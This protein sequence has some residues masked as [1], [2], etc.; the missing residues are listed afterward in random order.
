MSRKQFIFTIMGVLLSITG[1]AQRVL[2]DNDNDYAQRKYEFARKDTSNAKEGKVVPIEVHQWKI[3]EQFGDVILQNADTLMHGFQNAHF[4]YGR[5]GEY[6]TL[7]GFGS[8][9]LSRI[10]MNRT[11]NSRFMFVDPYSYWYTRVED[12]NFTNT[13]SPYTNITYQENGSKE[14]GDDRI[15][16]YFATNI[17]KNAGIGF[18]LDYLYGRGFYDNQPTSFFDGSLYGYYR[19]DEYDMHAWFSAK[20][21]KMGENGGIEDDEY[22]L[23]PESF[24]RSYQ[25]RDIPTNLQS[26]WNRNDSKTFYLNHHYNMGFYRSIPLPDSLRTPI[27]ADSVL[28]KLIPDSVKQT[29]AN[30][31][32]KQ[33][34]V[35]DSI[36]HERLYE[37][38]T[39]VF[40][41]VSSIFHTMKIE[42]YERIFQT[43]YFPES[44]YMNDYYGSG[45]YTYDQTKLFTIKNTVGLQLKEGFNKWAQAGLSAFATYELNAYK[46]PTLGSNG[47]TLEKISEHN[48]LV[49]G[50]LERKQGSLLHYDV[51][52]EIN[53][54]G[55]EVGS[56]KLDGKGE[57]NF[58]VL[59][60]TA[61]IKLNA[62]VQ[63]Q[64]PSFYFRHYHGR[65]DW[66]DNSLDKELRTTVGGEISWEKTRTTLKANVENITNYTYF[67]TVKAPVSQSSSQYS[68]AAE[69]KQEGGSIQ[70][71]TAQLLQ[72]FK[73]GILNWENELT[74]QL[75][76]DKEALPLPTFNAYSNLYLK[77][78]IAKV[79]SV[80]LGVDGFFF[81]KYYAPDYIP[82][83]GQY[84][85][86]AEETKTELG[87]TPACSAYINFHL[88]HCRFY[89][90]YSH[91][92]GNKLFLAPHYPITPGGLQFGLSWNFFN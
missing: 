49:G 20:H 30:L 16:A 79:L 87:G 72:N 29:W 23:H 19:G 33:Q 64:T 45:S 78:M 85:T 27:P 22:I 75:S 7:G 88:K 56:F 71:I 35:L 15:R 25:M 83:I 11:Q 73:W 69:V 68:M 36:K 50:R 48:F 40:V 32:G 57:L 60:D 5:N 84:A 86:Q 1:Y 55:E 82:G 80:E 37:G 8:P 14:N 26:T 51:V 59:G 18:K 4:T 53:I 3:N 43:K 41:P 62:K 28:L 24:S 9:R 58:K 66:W 54:A 52:G 17:S 46:I 89:V 31:P 10:Y 21:M 81:T 92:T 38:A 12:F 74:Y 70:V 67:A 44:F 76:S 2:D 61:H 47:E 6:N 65:T 91:I 13:K 63:H 90:Q 77:F 39:E 34:E 42:N